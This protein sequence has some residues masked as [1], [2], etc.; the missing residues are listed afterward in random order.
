MRWATLC[1]QSAA[2]SKPAQQQHSDVGCTVWWGKESAGAEPLLSQPSFVDNDSVSV[3]WIMNGTERTRQ[4]EADQS[5][6]LC[7]VAQ[8]LVVGV[9]MS[10]VDCR[11][12][13]C[14]VC[15]SVCLVLR[16][17]MNECMSDLKSPPFPA[18]KP[19]NAR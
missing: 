6:G 10:I 11:Y 9:S 16:T 17:Q 19:K 2:D 12:R 1:M 14:L 18:L 4:T 15:L 3:L 13:S 8:S 7:L 5:F